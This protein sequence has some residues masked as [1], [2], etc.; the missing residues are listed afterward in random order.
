MRKARACGAS[1]SHSYTNHRKSLFKE[2]DAEYMIGLL[3]FQKM[4]KLIHK[5]RP[6]KDCNEQKAIG[7]SKRK[8]I[9][10]KISN[11]PSV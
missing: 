9:I 2:C 5:I 10:E 8:G 4:K 1:L 7:I 11:I 3:S 6:I